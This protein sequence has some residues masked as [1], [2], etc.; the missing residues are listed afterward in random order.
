MGLI[1]DLKKGSYESMKRKAEDRERW[2]VWLP[3]TCRE[4]EM[5]KMMMMRSWISKLANR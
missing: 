2:R 4:A 5:L 3:R 1:D